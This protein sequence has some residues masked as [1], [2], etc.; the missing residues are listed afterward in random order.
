MEPGK[1]NKVEVEDKLSHY[2]QTTNK[3]GIPVNIPV[4]D[5]RD[6]LA[7]RMLAYNMIKQNNRSKFMNY[8]QYNQ[9][10]RKSQSI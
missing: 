4:I 8:S 1:V 3:Y 2:L 10:Q 9:S 6:G 7:E 5:V